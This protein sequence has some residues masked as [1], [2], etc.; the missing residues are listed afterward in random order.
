[1]KELFTPLQL[2]RV[3]LQNRVVMAPMTRARAN[4]DGTPGHLAAQYYGQRASV[5][6]IIT[7]GTQPSDDG[8][9]YPATP[10]IYTDAHVAGWRKVTD[11]I[12]AQGA[13]V[14]FQLMHAGRMSHPDNTLHGRQGVAPSAIAPGEQIFTLAGMKDIPV[15]RA[16]ATEEIPGTIN[17]YRHAARRAIE[18]GADG[19]EIHG[20]AYL[21]HQFLA[22]SANQRSDQ[23]GGSLV[24]RARFAIEVAQAV[25]DEVGADR[26]GIRISPGFGGMG[27]SHGEEGPDL[28]RYLVGELNKL[29]L[30]YLHIV[31][32]G[33]EPLLHDLRRL[34]HQALILN[35][36]ERPRE[37]FG[38]DVA[39][40]LAELESYG[41]MTLANPDFI[42]RLKTGAPLNVAD[43]ATYF[44]VSP[45]GYATGYT[46]YP[47]LI[48]MHLRW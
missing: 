15:P 13:R 44:G 42:A 9:G 8:Q 36:P 37:D 31:H 16:L 5:G 35:R 29:S 18:A 30:V 23:Y 28:Y 19:V 10:G 24:N 22:L 27:L 1:M 4:V 17:E 11:A 39:S 26:T 43:R 47:R 34:W 48:P 40:G 7:E 14:F 38:T 12:H 2:G 6:L 32:Y 25:V 3:F 41:Q 45:D 33:D 21:I 20:V 46:D